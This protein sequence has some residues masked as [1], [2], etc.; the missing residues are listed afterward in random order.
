MNV[1][2]AVPSESQALSELAV[3]AKGFW[4]Y[5]A[6]QLAAWASDL[7]ISPESIISEP[8]FVAEVERRIAGVVQLSTKRV[9]WSI[10]HLWVLPSAA[11]RGIGGQLVR[12]VIQYV[13][14]RG[15]RELLIDSDPEAEGFYIR[16]GARKVGEVAAPIEGQPGRVRPQ[17]VVS[18][19]NAA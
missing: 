19:E 12:H 16:L 2:R 10:E 15:Q 9:P 11:R 1:R 13:H 3:A 7:R 14:E 6:A 5:P 17:F 8:T 18:T 4:G